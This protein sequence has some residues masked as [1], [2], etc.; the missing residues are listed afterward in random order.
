MPRPSSSLISAS[1]AFYV[2][3]GYPLLLAALARWFE[4]PVLK[5][6]IGEP[7]SVII[8]VRNGERWLRQKLES[9]LAL[10]YPADAIDI[11]I[12]SDGSTD[13]TD[14]IV[15]SYA[16]RRRAPHDGS[17]GRNAPP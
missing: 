4:R 14:E 6:E 17:F 10:D 2:L 13:G 9:V 12:V 8:A 11:T 3:A 15:R 1:A 16:A 5:R 7:V